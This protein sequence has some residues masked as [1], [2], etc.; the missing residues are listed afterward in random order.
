MEQ[1]RHRT[2]KPIP[3]SLVK[4]DCQPEITGSKKK[5]DRVKW[6]VTVSYEYSISS[7]KFSGSWNTRPNK[8]DDSICL[9]QEM[10][11]IMQEKKPLSSLG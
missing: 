6:R 3:V 1:V 9:T 8:P 5:S 2:W 10:R 4:V 11:E 7:K